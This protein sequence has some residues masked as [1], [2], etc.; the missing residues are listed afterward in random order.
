[1]ADAII[2]VVPMDEL[3]LIVELYNQI[4]RPS[5]DIESFR[6]R[7]LGRY[8]ILQMVARV[9][10][11]P[12]GFFLGFELKPTTFFAWFYGVSPDYRRQGI[13]SQL[14]EAAHS[15]AKS[16]EYEV[17]RLECHNQHRPL[18]H[19]AIVLGYNVVGIRWDAD[20]TDNLVLF[21]KYLD[22]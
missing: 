7:Y 4:F 2:E 3:P 15:W 16:H 11:K 1:M 6:R 8:N 5:K 19:L 18:L 12:V 13:A 10:E 14:M 9:E 20:R 21:E 22:D 17:M